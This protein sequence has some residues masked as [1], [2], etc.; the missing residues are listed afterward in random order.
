MTLLL[1]V[2]STAISSAARIGGRQPVDGY[3]G[4]TTDAAI[5][6]RLLATIHHPS[7]HQTAIDRLFATATLE[8]LVA[9]YRGLSWYADPPWWAGRAASGLRHSAADVFAA[10]ALDND[11]PA[12][13][14]DQDGFNHLVLK[15]VFLG[16][17]LDR[18][19]GVDQRANAD[20]AAMLRSY[21]HERAAAKRTVD[22]R[23]WRW[24]GSADHPST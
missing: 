10:V 7:Q 18:I 3:H 16:L 13:H 14:L 20:L 19:R 9:L 23:L 17:D 15:A 4:W 11:Y 6:V 12:Q 5:R 2:L 22:P 24:A 1:R 8:E 21:A